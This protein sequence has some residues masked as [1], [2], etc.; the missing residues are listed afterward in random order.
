MI[1]RSPYLVQQYFRIPPVTRTIVTLQL[2]LSLAAKLGFLDITDVF[3]SWPLIRA[4]EVHRLITSALYLGP[5]SISV[6]FHIYLSF[7]S[8]SSQLEQYRFYHAPAKYTF[9]LATGVAMFMLANN[10]PSI[11]YY[12]LVT[13]LSIFILYLNSKYSM[14]RVIVLVFMIPSAAA[15][16][17]ILAL[18]V[19]QGSPVLPL[20]TAILCA[21]VFYWV[22]QVLPAITAQRVD[23]LETVR[24]SIGI[25]KIDS[26]YRRWIARDRID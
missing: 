9:A 18:N 11:H 6:L 8:T 26:L 2:F 1:S 20:L 3:L 25:N 4:G 10:L 23:P 21:H 5:L 16:W 7:L 12:S 22:D 13:P 24:A 17:V 14:G 19:L 15:P